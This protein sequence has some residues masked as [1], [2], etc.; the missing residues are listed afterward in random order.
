MTCARAAPARCP[1]VSR[2]TGWERSGRSCACAAQSGRVGAFA[3]RLSSGPAHER[4]WATGAA[5]EEE[6]AARLERLLAEA[7]VSVLHD[8]HLPGQR[9]NIDHI[10]IGPS[11]VT[12]V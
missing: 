10:A 7:P 4:A 11:G 8:R 2:R 6:N 3:A 1:P 5:G 9:A 12:V